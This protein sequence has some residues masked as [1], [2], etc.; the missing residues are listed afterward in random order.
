[1][2]LPEPASSG[3]AV[4]T[5]GTGYGPTPICRATAP[6]PTAWRGMNWT[7]TTGSPAT[8]ST[9]AR[10]CTPRRHAQ[11]SAV[12]LD[13]AGPPRHARSSSTGAACGSSASAAEQ[14]VVHLDADL[15]PG[16]G[17]TLD[18]RYEGN[19]SPRRGPVGRSGLGGTHR[20]RAGR[21][22]AQRRRRPGFPA[23][24][25]RGTRQA[26]GSPSPPTPITGPCATAGW[27]GTA[28]GPA[29]RPG[30]MSRQSP[31]PRTWPRSR[32]AGTSS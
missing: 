4:G 32:S 29:G 15:P 7:W 25:T 26:T 27:W 22:P 17:F 8:G 1:M 5:A 10:S 2:S 12:V 30:S 3:P 11:A 6:A 19:P 23:T 20:R 24:T 14:L 9:A 28:S 16:D 18:I 31:W 21:G 13:L